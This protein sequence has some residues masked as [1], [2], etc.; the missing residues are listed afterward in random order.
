MLFRSLQIHSQA[1]FEANRDADADAH[2]HAHAEPLDLGVAQLARVFAADPA[3]SLAVEL[4]A[5]Q[6][7][8]IRSI[9]PFLV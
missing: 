8:P 2:A 4:T 1:D 3:V 9:A 7:L 6:R 5:E